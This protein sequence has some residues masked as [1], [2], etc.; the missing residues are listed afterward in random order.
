MNIS[1]AKHVR[2]QSVDV[3]KIQTLK[4]KFHDPKLYSWIVSKDP[5][6]YIHSF[7]LYWILS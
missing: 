6:G 4:Y 5:S 7:L 3:F 2:H 1:I